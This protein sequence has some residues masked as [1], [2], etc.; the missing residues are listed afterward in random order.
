MHFT[1]L[2]CFRFIKGEDPADWVTVDAE[3]GRVTTSKI[4]DHESPYV[5]DS[6]YVVTVYAVDDGMTQRI[7]T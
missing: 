4:I 2:T 7:F 6:V 3:T 5:K 1:M